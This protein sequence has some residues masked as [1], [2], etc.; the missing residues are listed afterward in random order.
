MQVVLTSRGDK[1]HS[2][3]V[4]SWN[5]VGS[6]QHLHYNSSSVNG[7]GNASSVNGSGNASSVDGSG[8]GSSV[9]GSGS[10]SSVDSSGSGSSVDG[11]GSESSVDESGSESSVD[12]SG[13]ESSVDGSGSGSSVDGSGSGSSVDG[14]G[15]E[16]VS[17]S[18]SSS[19]SGED[20]FHHRCDVICTGKCEVLRT[21]ASSGTISDG[22]F[23]YYN[24]P[25]N[26]GRTNPDYET[27]TPYCK[28]LVQN[29]GSD[30]PGSIKLDFIE[31]FGT[32]FLW[33]REQA[34]RIDDETV[35]WKNVSNGD[36]VTI[37]TCSNSSCIEPARLALLSGTPG[38]DATAPLIN[39]PA[40][41]VP[42]KFNSSTGFLQLV[43]TTDYAKVDIGWTA[44]WSC[45]PPDNDPHFKGWSASSGWEGMLEAMLG[46]G[47]GSSVDGSGSGSSVHGSGSGS[48]VNGSGSG[49]SVDGSGSGSSVD[50]SGSGSSVD[51][52]GSG[53]S[54]DGSGSGSSVD[55]S[56]SGSMDY[57]A[58]GM[59]SAAAGN[60]SAHNA[61][62]T[63]TCDYDG[64]GI[65]ND[66]DTDDDN[67]GIPDDV[68]L[69]SGYFRQVA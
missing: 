22:P 42:Y 25:E 41:P 52:S 49:S 67:D 59:M 19:G 4:A 46:G 31:T 6:P 13:S 62:V 10:G 28:C 57:N 35:D 47:S 32:E 1:A 37:N 30:Q 29:I 11:S 21:T 66:L 61:T 18:G 44:N 58:N 51:G 50:G 55:G 65:P 64:D 24:T 68:D 9:D 27:W 2:G 3:F 14:S 53:S 36:F 45:M 60:G 26:Y 16:G 63:C 20:I 39:D 54:V 48:S 38:A 15:S 5:V 12:E 8:S 34:M 40:S 23:Q 43:F 56:G 7:S 33:R 69:F 17:I